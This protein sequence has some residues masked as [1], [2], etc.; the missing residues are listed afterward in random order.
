MLYL[1]VVLSISIYTVVAIIILVVVVVTSNSL[2]LLG[3]VPVLGGAKS[4]NLDIC[5]FIRSFVIKEFHVQHITLSIHV[6]TIEKYLYPLSF[7]NTKRRGTK[8]NLLIMFQLYC[9]YNIPLDC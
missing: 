8:V 3:G 5:W 2:T 4:F 7:M 9:C 6:L 1:E